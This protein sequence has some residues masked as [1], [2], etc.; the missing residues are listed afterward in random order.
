[1]FKG[2]LGSYSLGSSKHSLTDQ[3]INL[4]VNTFFRLH[5]LH[6]DWSVHG[7]VYILWLQCLPK[8][9]F[10]K[11]CCHKAQLE[12]QDCQPFQFLY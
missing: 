1:M 2:F 8:Y 9:L 12:F 6:G 4:D 10:F 3:N 7:E 5:L 11:T